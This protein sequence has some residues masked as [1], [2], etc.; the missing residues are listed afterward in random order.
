MGES[1]AHLARAGEPDPETRVEAGRR[2]A[3]LAVLDASS[4][5]ERAL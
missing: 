2:Q 1:V 4:Y 5:F 3:A